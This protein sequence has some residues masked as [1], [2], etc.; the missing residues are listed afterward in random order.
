MPF[1]CIVHKKDPCRVTCEHLLRV[2]LMYS[3]QLLITQG[4]TPSPAHIHKK[5]LYRVT[6][7]HLLRVH[8]MYTLLSYQSL[9]GLPQAPPTYIRRTHIESHVNTY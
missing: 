9:R 1:L 3:A 5:D 6:C 8:L 7:E 4:L 2:H